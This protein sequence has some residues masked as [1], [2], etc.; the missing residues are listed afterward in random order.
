MKTDI[1][2]LGIIVLELLLSPGSTATLTTLR[3]LNF[4]YLNNKILVIKK[5]CLI[6]KSN[7]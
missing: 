5:S 4:Y 7:D 3:F 2:S 1:Y 6:K